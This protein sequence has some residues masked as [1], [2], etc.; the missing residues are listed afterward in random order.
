MKLS[1]IVF[2]WIMSCCAE[3]A[4]AQVTAVPEEGMQQR[5]IHKVDPVLNAE[6]EM[7]IHGTVVLKAVIDKAGNIDSLQMVSGHP[8]LVPAA[9][10]AVKEWK[11]RPYE[12]NGIAVPVE[13]TVRVEFPDRNGNETNGAPA[14]QSSQSPTTPVPMP[15]DKLE[16][17]ILKRVPPVYPPLARA[18]RIQGTVM[19]KVIID[20]AGNVLNTQ[21]VSGHPMLAPAAVE[22]VKQWKY[23]PFELNG[24]TVEIE[25]DVQVNFKLANDPAKGT[26][27]DAPGGVIGG[28]FGGVIAGSRA[29]LG[30]ERVS[31][32]V[33][34]PLRLQKV[35]PIYPEVAVQ[36]RIQGSVI[37]ELQIDPSGNVENV[38][39]IS[40][41][42]TLAPAAIEAVKQWKYI[43]YMKDGKAIAVASVVRLQFSLRENGGAG[44][45]IEP[46]ALQDE[47]APPRI[48]VPRRIRVSSGVSQGLV[49]KKVAPEY[50]PE[51]REGHI[52]GVVLLRTVID[53]E[54]NVSS[55]ELISGHP[56]L[57]P[58]AIEAVRQWKYR[59]YLLNGEAIE[60]ETQI[61]VSFVL[62]R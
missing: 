56:A 28:V 50:P 6:P 57:A 36:Q 18:A 13:T 14:P 12:V 34:R 17:H 44:G 5:L 26:V 3:V 31:E 62:T 21:L 27:G 55:V 2:L 38:W 7:R 40:G 58:A 45:V 11:Y 1:S 9:I 51:A 4:V 10:D 29:A 47:S 19:L 30:V 53:K 22:A 8:M 59:P 41:H 39:L 35:D 61:Q 42:P 54:G 23:V 20:R 60:V 49:Q 52:E 48:G 37:L 32:A 25:T 15:H 24:E 33:L 43:A 46:E 16:G